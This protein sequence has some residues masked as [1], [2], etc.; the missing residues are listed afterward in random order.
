MSFGLSAVVQQVVVSSAVVPS[1]VVSSTVV[2]SAV[3]AVVLSAVGT[4]VS[5]QLPL[6]QPCFGAKV[7]VQNLALEYCLL[8]M[9]KDLKDLRV[10]GEL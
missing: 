9:V 6:Q 4:V 7:F 8:K 3:A 5:E 2:P 10:E 1:A